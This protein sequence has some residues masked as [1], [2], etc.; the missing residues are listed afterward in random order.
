MMR[1]IAIIGAGQAG[2]LT[3]HGLLKA[4][5]T[6][7]LYSDKTPEQFLNEGRPTGTAVRFEP[8][9]AYERELG[10]NF[11]DDEAPKIDGV[12]FRLGLKP[13]NTLIRLNG[14]IANPAYGIDLRLQ[15]HRWLNEFVA[16]GGQLHVEQVS[17]DRL[18]EIAAVHDLVVVAAGRGALQKLFPRNAERSVYDKPQ[19]NLAMIVVKGP[20][21]Q[22]PDITYSPVCYN[23]ILSEGEAFWVPYHHKTLG[24]TWN[25]VIEAKPGRG[26]DRFGTVTSGAEAVSVFKEI[27]R[28]FFPADYQWAKNM[29]LADPNGWLVGRFAPTVRNAVGT[30]PSGRVVTGVGDA[31]MSLDPVGGQGA[32][33]GNKMARHLVQSIVEHGERPFSANWMTE[34]FERFYA[35]HGEI[36]NRFNNLLLEEV[37]DAGK[38]LLIAQHG[39]DGH[40][41]GAYG[42]QAIADAF[43]HNFEDPRTLTNAFE[44][45]SLA[46]TIISERM[47]EPWWWSALNGRL[48]VGRDQIR[49][50]FAFG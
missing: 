21:M 11:W 23:A 49:Q 1:K 9:L 4:G 46:R 6:V 2:L 15:S 10:L 40:V 26:F 29:E 19:R 42:K 36:T 48:A 37:P 41:N 25:M 12:R 17:V 16:R 47:Q 43:C 34:T 45:M 8:A 44:D 3:A 24:S 14:R 50:R 39:S 32:N 30:L 5:Y 22:V 33:N 27:I 35:D 31:L 28:D 20:S 38:E 7:S 18:D 13:H